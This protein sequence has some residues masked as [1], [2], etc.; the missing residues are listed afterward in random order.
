MDEGERKKKEEIEGENLGRE[1]GIRKWTF[2]LFWFQK[3]KT[4][5]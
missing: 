1:R 4:E 2:K 3:F 5:Q